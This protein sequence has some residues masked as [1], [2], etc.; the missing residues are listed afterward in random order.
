GKNGNFSSSAGNAVTFDTVAGMTIN[1]GERVTGTI[2][3]ASSIRNLQIIGAAWSYPDQSVQEFTMPPTAVRITKLDVG[4]GG[5][6]LQGEVVVTNTSADTIYFQDVALSY[7]IPEYHF[8]DDG[9]QL[10]NLT[11]NDL[12]VSSGVPVP[13]SLT[14]LAGGASATFDFGAGL[15]NA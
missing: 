7:N 14:S 12:F 3:L 6:G 15:V 10:A 9:V 4:G 1:T 2:S 8:F 5:T 13:V 11:T